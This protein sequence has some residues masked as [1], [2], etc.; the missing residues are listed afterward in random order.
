MPAELPRITTVHKPACIVCPHYGA[1]LVKIG[2]HVRER[3]ACKPN[4]FFVRRDL[5]P[6]Y[7]CHPCEGVVAESVPPAIFGSAQADASLLAQV[8]VTKYLDHLPLYQQEGTYA[9]SGVSLPRSTLAE[10]IGAV[11]VALQPLLDGLH[12]WLLALNPDVLGN[13][14]ATKAIDYNLKC[15]T[16][17]SRYAE[18]GR[19]PID[20]NP[21]ENA[22]RAIALGRK[23]GCSPPRKPPALAV[24]VMSLLATAKANNPDPHAWLCDVQERLPTTKDRNIDTLLPYRWQHFRAST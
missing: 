13:S 12:A 2:G 15:W 4:A 24:A 19:Y 21:I 7:A 9:R 20:N 6:Q 11:G 22:I 1:E 3:L 10:W 18:E 14:G 5:V 23:T 17:L 16:A 8:T